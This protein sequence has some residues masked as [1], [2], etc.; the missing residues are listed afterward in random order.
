MQT[1][2]ADPPHSDAVVLIATPWW[3]KAGH[4]AR[5]SLLLLTAHAVVL[6]AF[7]PLRVAS[8]IAVLASVVAV[9]ML[10]RPG[11]S[12]RWYDDRVQVRAGRHRWS[13]TARSLDLDAARIVDVPDPDAPA[14][15]EMGRG[16]FKRGTY[17]GP[18]RWQHIDRA[19]F[20]AC[21]PG[22]ALLVP[23]S[24]S[25][26]LLLAGPDGPQALLEHL[27]DRLLSPPAP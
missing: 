9:V 7:E 15:P 14:A 8:F 18:G 25:Q 5:I 19:V 13:T 26:C 23:V 2:S 1:Y 4:L 27:R 24:P 12:M 6:V 22:P 21:P 11:A 17:L 20:C 16:E 3:R 10:P